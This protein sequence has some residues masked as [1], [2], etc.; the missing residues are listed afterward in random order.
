ML[1]YAF[2]HEVFSDNVA[3]PDHKTGVGE[4]RNLDLAASESRPALVRSAQN[5]QDNVFYVRI[6]EAIYRG[7]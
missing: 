2:I 7:R 3:R 6:C 5:I 4:A 1:S